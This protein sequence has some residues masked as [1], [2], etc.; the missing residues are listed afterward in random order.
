[1]A[2]ET[3]WPLRLP[4][5]PETWRER[6]TPNRGSAIRPEV[7]EQTR[8]LELLARVN[9]KIIEGKK[10]YVEVDGV[11]YKTLYG[12]YWRSVFTGIEHH[13]LRC[14]RV[15]GSIWAEESSASNSVDL[16]IAFSS[17]GWTASGHSLTFMLSREM[18][19]LP[20]SQSRLAR[21]ARHYGA[22]VSSKLKRIARQTRRLKIGA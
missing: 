5:Q 4:Y 16:P 18:M 22:T 8:I 14:V 3:H 15:S 20:Q 12:G 6:E 17:N 19:G 13:L 21:T 10:V 7:R 11:V 9:Y 2:E 1:M